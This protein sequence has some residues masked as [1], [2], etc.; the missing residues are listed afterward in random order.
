M[1]NDPPPSPF[2][3][4]GNPDEPRK[5]D[6]SGK[7]NPPSSHNQPA[8]SARVPEKVGRGVFASGVLVV[9]GPQELVLDFVAAFSRP[10]AHLVS[11][12]IVTHTV[13]EQLLGALQENFK[14]YVG[15]YGAPPMMPKPLQPEPRRTLQEIYDEIKISDDVLCGAYSNAAMVGH[16]PAEFNIEFITGFF[17]QA[18]VSSRVYI[19]APRMPQFIESLTGA[20]NQIRAQNRP[21]Q[22]PQPPQP[23]QPPTT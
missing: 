16:T 11:R 1:S 14:R 23:P 21:S 12:V 20:L 5:P 7:G 6:D 8:I 18:A 15:N 22:T 13:A 19:A 9:P 4:G 10:P 17:P 2:P 3:Y